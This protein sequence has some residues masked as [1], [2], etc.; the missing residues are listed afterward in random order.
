MIPFSYFYKFKLK[1]KYK[2]QYS[3]KIFLSKIND[4]FYN[5]SSLTNINLSNFNTQ[6]VTNMN[7]MFSLC[8]SLTN[9]NLSNFNNQ[10]VTNIWG[11]FF[12]CRSLKNI[13]LSILILKM[14]LI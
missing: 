11:M 4:M 13:N 7:H 3:F 10:N 14:L 5:C 2:I 9:I 12:A 6:N 1:G 8:I